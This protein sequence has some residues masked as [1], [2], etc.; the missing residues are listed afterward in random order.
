MIK[1]VANLMIKPECIDDAIAL[2][3]PFID[4]TRA[5]DGC[6]SYELFQ[7]ME[8]PCAF[9]FIEEWETQE[10]CDKHLQSP[11]FLAILPQEMA[12][13][14]EGTALVVNLLHKIK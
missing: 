3:D 4:L 5:E 11:N 13:Q 8:D 6:R 2:Y 7:G 14:Q 12:M 10:D 9:T 1:V